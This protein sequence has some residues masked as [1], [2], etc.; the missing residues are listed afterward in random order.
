MVAKIQSFGACAVTSRP[1]CSMFMQLGTL[2]LSTLHRWP[3]RSQ[4]PQCPVCRE[5]LPITSRDDRLE[6][7]SGARTRTHSSHL[8]P[9]ST[10]VDSHA[11]APAL[12]VICSRGQVRLSERGR[13][14]RRPQ[15]CR[16][17]HRIR[18]AMRCRPCRRATASAGTAP[19]TATVAVIT[20]APTP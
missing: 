9:T 5:M 18:P 3:G 16:R 15:R 4:A 19:S 2:E 17:S 12:T 1:R 20:S 14:T 10:C 8:A 11:D 13:H 7:G 6:P